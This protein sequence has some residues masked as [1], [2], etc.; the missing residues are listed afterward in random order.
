MI[1]VF[2]LEGEASTRQGGKYYTEGNPF[3]SPQ[4][5]AWARESN[6]LHTFTLDP[7]AGANNLIRMLREKRLCKHYS[8]FDIEPTAKDVLKRDSLV[9]FPKG[10]SVCIT[11]P[12]WLARNSATRLGLS[13]PDCAYDDLYKHCLN[14]CLANCEFVAAIVPATFLQADLFRARLMSYTLL[15]RKVFQD[16]DN[17]ACLALFGSPSADVE[18][19]YDDL[20]VGNLREL[21]AFLPVPTADL[22]MNFNDNDGE[23]GFVSFDN[24]EAPSIRFCLAN[25]LSSYEI[26]H[27]SRFITRIKIDGATDTAARVLRLNQAVSEFRA[28]TSDVF[29]TPF[30]GLRQDGKCRRRMSYAL[31]RSLINSV[32]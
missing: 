28:D 17:P 32:G 3:G 23:L 31:A 12:P 10:Y 2:D 4:F 29:L 8:S 30:K 9:V 18:I 16:T 11:N 22:P 5:L 19:F 20:P 27:S 6:M 24:T 15:Q 26:K 25:E 21:E 14:L 7:F 1:C 13:F